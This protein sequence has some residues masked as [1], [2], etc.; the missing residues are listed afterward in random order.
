M[1]IHT[2]R[3]QHSREDKTIQY[4]PGLNTFTHI[5]TLSAGK[6]KPT[7]THAD[8]SV[9]Q[10][11]R[12]HPR[13]PHSVSKDS[14]AAPGQHVLITSPHIWAFTHCYNGIVARTDEHARATHARDAFWQ[15]DVGVYKFEPGDSF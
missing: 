8:R 15:L 13:S 2:T 10:V 1:L 9:S 11:S 5:F 6:K 4:R 14:S 7:R 12:T 3:K